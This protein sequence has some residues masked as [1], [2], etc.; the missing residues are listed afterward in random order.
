METL[1]ITLDSKKYIA[2]TN[3]TGKLFREASYIADLLSK[4]SLTSAMLD[5]LYQFVCSVYDNQFDVDELESQVDARDALST[6]YESVYYINNKVSE[7]SKELSQ[8]SKEDDSNKDMTEIVMDMYIGLEDLGYT[9]NQIDEIDI[10][11]H[12]KKLGR[13]KQTNEK[14][15]K[16]LAN[17]DYITFD[18][19]VDSVSPPNKKERNGVRFSWVEDN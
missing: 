15:D 13:R 5:R 2:S 11:Y 7:A 10:I 12:I 18:K 16:T 4:E 6:I 14:Q 8:G 1:S 9:Q 3:I 19:V 17:D